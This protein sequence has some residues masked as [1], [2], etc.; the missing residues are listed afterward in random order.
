MN[1]HVL[2]DNRGWASILSPKSRK[3]RFFLVGLVLL[4]AGIAVILYFFWPR[5]QP[6]PLP[7]RVA[8][9]LRQDQ[10]EKLRLDT[11]GDGLKDWEE[12]LY[13]TD[14]QNP[15]TDGDGT[16]DGREA[17]DNRDPLK[18]G[19]DDTL[20]SPT[21]LEISGKEPDTNLTRDFTR[22]F[23]RKPLA[24]IIAGE[25]ADID[26]RAVERYAERLARQSVLADAARFTK[27]DI[28]ISPADTTEAIVQ[29]FTA[30][31]AVFDMLAKR[32]KNE[33]DITVDAF[34]TQNY[35]ALAALTF[36]PDAYA[37]AVT[38]LKNTSAPQSVADFHLAILNYL[39]KFKRSVELM[40]KAEVDPILAML[41][42]HERMKLDLQFNASLERFGKS[43]I[44]SLEKMSQ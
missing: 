5:R 39:P 11:D 1:R 17:A 6:A 43:I 24:Q 23:L 44:A 35:G 4:A 18:A 25:E 22:T 15:D 16:P 29:Y 31:G 30:F 20:T 7:E 42:M 13:R 40:Q 9:N 37:R 3:A 14:P 8:L 2:D 34:K 33:V 19:P 10:I 12:A 26:T 21:P 27:A 38:E 36:Y 28:K 32:G 41:A